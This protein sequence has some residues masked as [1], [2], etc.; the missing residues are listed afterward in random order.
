MEEEEAGWRRKLMEKKLRMM[1][2]KL[3]SQEAVEEEKGMRKKRR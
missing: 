2:S 1:G 3:M